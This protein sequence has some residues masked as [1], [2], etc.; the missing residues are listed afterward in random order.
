MDGRQ[1]VSPR[2][3]L[4]PLAE[5]TTTAKSKERSTRSPCSCS[6]AAPLSSPPGAVGTR[7]PAGATSSPDGASR[8]ERR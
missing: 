3:D 1:S 4:L 6:A 8:D 7:G 2:N 5:A